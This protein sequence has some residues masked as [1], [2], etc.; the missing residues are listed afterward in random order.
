MCLEDPLESRDARYEFP[1]LSPNVSCDVPY[2][3]DVLPDGRETLV[4]GD[5]KTLSEYCHRQGDNPF[6]FRGT[7]GL[8]SCEGIMRQ[9]G[10]EVTEADVVAYA[11]AHG[12]CYVEGDSGMRGG[13]TVVEQ[14]RILSDFGVPA[15]HES[16]CSLEDLAA[17]LEHGRGVIVAL[18]CGVL[19]DD[20]NYYDGRAN[21]AV[22]PI[23]VARDP[24]T[25]QIQGFYV[26]DTGT[27]ESGRFV[28]AATMDEAW[29]Q[30]GGTC[31]VTDRGH[32]RNEQRTAS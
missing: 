26:N 25:G 3:L 11:I 1:R 8:C 12:L 14:V 17:S 13:S 24:E 28:D 21:H 10:L 23:G 5:V 4:T 9:F 30:L 18:D 2:H 29:V 7:C 15:H 19:W 16:T 6:G 32:L 20:A 31:V 22:T 27:G